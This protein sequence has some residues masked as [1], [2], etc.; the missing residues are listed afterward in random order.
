[1]HLPDIKK[2]RLFKRYLVFVSSQYLLLIEYTDL[3]CL[4]LTKKI[5]E[6]T[7]NDPTLLVQLLNPIFLI[8]F[9]NLI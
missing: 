7:Q 9:L 6:T 1:M 2:L 3:S 4:K 5:S 8:N